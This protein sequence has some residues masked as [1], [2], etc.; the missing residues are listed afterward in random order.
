MNPTLK[1]P[2]D[3]IPLENLPHNVSRETKNQFQ[4]FI[5]LVFLWQGKINLTGAKSPQEYC[6]H[7]LIDCSQAL[8]VLPDFDYCIDV[9]AGSGLP[10]I[11]WALL[12]PKK[13]FLLVESLQKRASFLNRVQSQLGMKNVQV[14]PGRFEK[15]VP[16]A[17]GIPQTTIM[18]S[19]GTSAP[20]NLL[21][22]ILL[23]PIQF[24]AWYVFATE[25]TQEEFLTLGRKSDM[26]IS[27]RKY[28]R[29]LEEK[30]PSGI[31][32]EIFPRHLR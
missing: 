14:F 6:R 21:K 5:D 1:S 26:Q 12:K 22:L 19:R 32:M 23:S 8:Q 11:V 30:Q 31:L 24:S 3:N 20:Q 29:D 7:H 16:A 10:G 18:V 9:G 25:R 15:Y 4:K 27:S 17:A 28:F 13:E 2:G